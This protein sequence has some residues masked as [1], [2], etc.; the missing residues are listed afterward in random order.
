MSSRTMAFPKLPTA[1]SPHLRLLFA[2]FFTGNLVEKLKIEPLYFF[3]IKHENSHRG[4][5]SPVLRLAE[6]FLF[7]E[8][9]LWL[10]P[11]DFDLGFSLVSKKVRCT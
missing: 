8:I 7:L 9:E 11:L 2:L 1:V 6:S 4:H 3:K 10:W 5:L